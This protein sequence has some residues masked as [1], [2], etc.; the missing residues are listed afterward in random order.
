VIWYV[1]PFIEVVEYKTLLARRNNY[2][3]STRIPQPYQRNMHNVSNVARNVLCSS[4]TF[5]L[6]TLE[7]MYR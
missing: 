2:N 3:H 1:L 5:K 4:I 7:Y 6:S